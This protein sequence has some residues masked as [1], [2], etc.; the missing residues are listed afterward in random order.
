[1]V[2]RLSLFNA[3]GEHVCGHTREKAG[4][5]LTRIEENDRT[6]GWIGLRRGKQFAHPLD[7]EF[8]R[9]QSR[10]YY[11]VGGGIL[12]VSLLVGLLLARFFAAPI[13]RLAAHAEALKRRQFGSRLKTPGS[14]EL[15][16]L[17]R[18]FNELAKTLG[19]YEKL[20]KQ[21]LSDISHELRTPLAVLRGE[22]EALQDG[23]R[24][25]DPE[26]LGSLQAEV[27]HIQ[28]LVDDLHGLA[29]AESGR[30]A[31]NLERLD[32]GL[33]L[34]Q[35]LAQFEARFERAGMSL[36]KRPESGPEIH[37][38]A[39]PKRLVQLL[40]N[41]LEN[42][43][44][45]ADRPGRLVVGFRVEDGQ[46]IIEVEDSGP[47]VAEAELPRLFDRLYRTDRS[48]S[49]TTG[50]SGLGLAICKAIAEGHGGSI[51]AEQGDL[52]GL[53]IRID[54]PL[55]GPEWNPEPDRPEQ[56]G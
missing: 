43:L 54:L 5:S 26:S 29:L 12:I 33:L 14:D 31:L 27:A 44:R 51:R 22:I 13:R 11:L 38:N 1:M 16:D 49:R 41:L 8:V 17:A 25:P 30:A 9:K 2:P 48:R 42:A 10:A 7:R 24:R 15:G 35:V 34:D 56:G 40:T 53:L 37:L 23:V 52:G 47:G 39:D 45:H 32:L 18:D 55:K 6:L 36:G 28:A 21:W 50:G 4:M 46:A 19:R 20:Q 3:Q